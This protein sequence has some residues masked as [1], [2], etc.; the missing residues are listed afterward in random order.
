MRCW[1][2]ANLELLCKNRHRSRSQGGG[3]N[4]EKRNPGRVGSLA[5][6]SAAEA[7]KNNQRLGLGRHLKQAGEQADGEKQLG[8]HSNHSQ[9]RR[10]NLHQ[11]GAGQEP[12]QEDASGTAEPRADGP[13]QHTFPCLSLYLEPEH[14]QLHQLT[15]RIATVTEIS[16]GPLCSIITPTQLYYFYSVP[17]HVHQ[18][19]LTPPVGHQPFQGSTE[20]RMPKANPE[21]VPHQCQPGGQGLSLALGG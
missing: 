3:D 21:Q 19:K 18:S 20:P 9:T 8:R 15:E 12:G 14:Q 11:L 1:G 4:A 13:C 16:T 5:Q 6:A 2:A 10:I 7:E 17:H